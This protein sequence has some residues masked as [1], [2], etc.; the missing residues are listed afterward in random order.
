M[1]L[2]SVAY[3]SPELESPSS[4]TAET[5]DTSFNNLVEIKGCVGLSDASERLA[6]KNQRKDFGVAQSGPITR[7]PI[8]RVRRLTTVLA[9]ASISRPLAQFP[10]IPWLLL[11]PPIPN[12]PFPAHTLFPRSQ[13]GL[14]LEGGPGFYPPEKF[15]NPILL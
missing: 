5:A 13:S 4:F 2:N 9:G 10:P 15:R 6:L 8:S 3:H 12:L 14:R 1:R 11:S 7:I